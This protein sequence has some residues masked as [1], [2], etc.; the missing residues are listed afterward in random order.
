MKFKKAVGAL[1]ALAI[2]VSTFAGM[3]VTANAA[4]MVERDY[5]GTSKTAE[6]FDNY[7]TSE[8]LYSATNS[9]YSFGKTTVSE[10]AKPGMGETAI[11][12]GAYYYPT[13]V[14]GDVI[15]VQ[16]R[17]STT[18]A[19]LPLGT[20]TSGKLYFK[21]NLYQTSQNTGYNDGASLIF[22]NADGED[23]I[24]IE[25]PGTSKGRFTLEGATTS[26]D[27]N[28]DINTRAGSFGAYIDLVIDLDSNEA[29]AV[30][31]YINSS[32]VRCQSTHT[33]DINDTDISTFNMYASSNRSSNTCTLSIDDTQLYTEYAAEQAGSVTLNYV[34]VNQNIVGSSEVDVS[35]L[36]AG[37]ETTCYYPK[38]IKGTDGI[39]YTPVNNIYG[40]N[41]V[42]TDLSQVIPI[43]YKK[44]EIDG[45]IVLFEDC[46]NSTWLISKDTAYSNG[47]AGSFGNKN[48][49]VST[50]LSK[51][52]Y[53][54]YIDVVSKAGNGSNYRGE[55]VSVNGEEVG[56]VTENSTGLKKVTIEVKED[57]SLVNVYG[58][59]TNMA[60]DNIDYVLITKT[61]EI[62]VPEPVEP[63]VNKTVTKVA[64]STDLE[65]N[66][67]V[68]YMAK[69]D[70]TGSYEVRG[71]LWTV[72]GAGDYS[73]REPQTVDKVFEKSTTITDG[74]IVFGLAIEAV[75]GLDTIGEVDAEL[76]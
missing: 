75:D 28:N 36:Y 37:D 27:Y 52:I 44:A 59:G 7:D 12:E 70:I 38:Y 33:V 10:I 20:L 65:G 69:F 51:G 41:I 64:E 6:T 72:K 2:T 23:V 24:R 57:N 25:I 16:Q 39:W 56:S 71:V 76:Q 47:T 49:I 11:N 32:H 35:S 53:D 15:T 67:A 9:S 45:D 63:S 5:I 74:S 13:Y 58:R 50:T 54:V 55:A 62:E 43:E 34:D 22:K 3:A 60:T 26:T 48:N 21:S 8:W 46:D 1:S 73:E 29:T 40:N 61:G 18:T 30:Y 17:K 31:D 66:E 19:T 68:S 14:N 4:S 42:L